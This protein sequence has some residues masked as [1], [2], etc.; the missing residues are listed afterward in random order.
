M[1]PGGAAITCKNE[2][3]KINEG[4]LC[5]VSS[6]LR[7]AMIPD[8][9]SQKITDMDWSKRP[10]VSEISATVDGFRDQPLLDSSSFIVVHGAG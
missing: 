10:G 1:G 9:I 2:M 4:N 6:H 3:E 8:S 7:Q 5:T